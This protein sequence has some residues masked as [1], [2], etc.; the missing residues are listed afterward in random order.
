MA[1]RSTLDF[2]LRNP[3]KESG[4]YMYHVKIKSSGV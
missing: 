4:K 2:M 1:A 3:L